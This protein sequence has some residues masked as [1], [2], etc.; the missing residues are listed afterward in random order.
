MNSKEE[1]NDENNKMKFILYYLIT[2]SVL[3]LGG[4]IYKFSKEDKKEHILSKNELNNLPSYNKLLYNAGIPY[5]D[6]LEPL[7]DEELNYTN[8]LDGG[9]NKKS[10]KKINKKIKKSKKKY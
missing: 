1:L 8:V 4:I 6:Y 9:N 2:A 3:S 10:K 5:P 7:H